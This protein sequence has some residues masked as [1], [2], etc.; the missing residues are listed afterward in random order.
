MFAHPINK[1]SVMYA[2][3]LI[4][5]AYSRKQEGFTYEVPSDLSLKEGSGVLV[6]FQRGEKAG[7]V[8]R[9]HKE[10]PEFQTKTIIQVLEASL[11]LA[12]WQ[13]KLAD[14]ICEYYFCSKYDAIKMMLPKHIWRAPKR[15]QKIASKEKTLSKAQNHTLTPDQEKIVSSIIKDKPQF[16]LIHGITGSGK[17]EVYK[18]V[19]QHVLGNTA[20]TKDS[21]KQ[22]LLLVPEISLTPQLVKYFEGSFPGITVIHSKISDGKRAEHWRKI[23]SGETQL[24]I[25][26]RS[27]I[28]SPFKNLGL[29]IMDEEH[30]WTYKQDQSPRYQT[31][32]VAKKIAELTGCQVI[33]GSATP[34][35]E[36]MWDAKEG[37]IKLYSLDERISGTLLPEV[38]IADMRDELRGGNF[39]ILSWKLEQKIRSALKAGEQIILFLN[40]R[41]SASSTICRDCGEALS[42]KNCDVKLTYHARKFKH[43][44]LICHHCGLIG[45]LPEC[46]PECKSPRIKH[47]GIGTQRV[48]SDLQKLFPAAK[49]CRADKDTMS[50]VDSFK[51][52]HEKLHKQEI[53]I[54][55]GT[56]M[57]GKGFDIPNVS[58][59]GVI[60]AD[61]GL[62]IPD[63]RAGERSFQLL[64]QVAGRAGRR[65]KQG[66]VVI[67]TY[68]PSHPA[69]QMARTHDYHS[70]FEQEISSRELDELPP[71]GKIVKLAFVDPDKAI[72][73]QS[74]TKLMSELKPINEKLEASERC[75]LFMSPALI[76]RINNKYHWHIIIQGKNAHKLV[77][78]I[79]QTLLSGWRIDVDPIQTV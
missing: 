65:K 58:L 30:E 78:E 70:F 15:K 41:G 32:A 66:Q 53:D 74:A 38:E 37:D 75:K 12:D 51:E 49:I 28:F 10:R 52:L 69:V 50:Q 62:H 45:K 46:C 33:F 56:Q 14:W 76:P 63:F 34:S 71:F 3:V 26:S 44:T 79:P 13:L 18:K 19:I 29:I 48:E 73:L 64:T 67:Q 60:M 23:K 40:R 43:Q 25:G 20:S 7:I 54:L 59:V 47:I 11:L 8:L 72:C 17:T 4:D 35:I 1:K 77:K 27:A 21:P 9:L 42:C 6:P 2:D 31:H 57:I 16:S 5:H 68:S 24:V 39:S 61:L 22:A 36:T 55:V